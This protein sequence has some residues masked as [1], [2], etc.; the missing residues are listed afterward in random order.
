MSVQ[1]VQREA[2]TFFEG[3]S[4]RS[5]QSSA[6]ASGLFVVVEIALMFALAALIYGLAKVA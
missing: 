2:G 5:R 4:E 3:E 6:R 1:D